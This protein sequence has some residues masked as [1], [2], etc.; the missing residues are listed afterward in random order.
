MA[1]GMVFVGD[2]G[3]SL[4]QTQ[5]GFRIIAGE[6][7]AVPMRMPIL[8]RLSGRVTD[9]NGPVAGVIVEAQRIEEATDGDDPGPGAF[10]RPSARTKADGSYELTDLSAGKY[11]LHW[12]K[13]SQLTKDLMSL[14]IP[15]STPSLEQDLALRYGSL[16]V[17]VTDQD[18][19]PIENATVEGYHSISILATN[20]TMLLFTR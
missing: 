4:S 6:S 1:G 15:V 2:E 10:Q 5:V 20:R 16:R 9:Q 3:E 11:E 7:I 8:T 18:G 19:E 12:G 17:Q 14:Q 13:P